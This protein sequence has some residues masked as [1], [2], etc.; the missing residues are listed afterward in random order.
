MS[1]LNRS[2]F[3]PSA[4]TAKRPVGSVRRLLQWRSAFVLS[5]GS[6]LLVTVSLGPMGG[7]LGPALVIVWVLT[8]L[9]GLLQCLFIAE[10]ASRYPDKVGGAPAYNHEGL[11]HLSPLFGAVSTWG[12]WV[13]WIPGVAVNLTLA[14]TYIKAAFLPKVNVL[15]LTLALGMLLYT[16]N[17][18]GLRLSVWISGT[19]ALCALIPLVVLLL[20]PVFRTSLWN[21][22]NFSPLLPKGLLW[23]SVPTLLLFA[24]WMFVAVWSSYGGEMVATIIGELRDPR[25]DLPKVV[26]MAAGATSLAFVVVPLVLVGIVGADRLAQ[27][28]YVVFLTATKEIFGGLGTEIVSLMLIAALFLGAQLFIISSSRA[29]Y[30]MSK[31]G[32]T[33]Q[34]YS[35]LNRYGVPVGS[36]GWD[37]VVT[38]SLLAIFKDNVVNVVA[39]ANV[40][41]LLVFVLLPLSYILARTNPQQIPATF[42]LPPFMTP[43]ALGIFVY[44][45]ILLLVGGVQWGSK[46]MGVGTFLVLTFIPFYICRRRPVLAVNSV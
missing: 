14:S 24:K 39:A 28:P 7:D 37:A 12:Y 26:G 27:D 23:Y 16:L 36:V 3:G 8:A 40:G 46:V 17:Y 15:G 35:R 38:L 10:L 21:G 43:V 45:A 33:I 29:L 2:Q 30:G 32:L 31:A 22:A 9:I 20:S 25:R 1:S 34:S 41:Y 19:T 44:N 42:R 6:A 4:T 18:F 13:G 11:K 5:L